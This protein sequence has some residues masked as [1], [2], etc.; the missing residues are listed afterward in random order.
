MQ[1]TIFYFMEIY[2]KN[3]FYVCEPKHA[4]RT[5]GPTYGQRALWEYLCT[6]LTL[7]LLGVNQA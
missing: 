5:G 6:D 1:T 3:V 4:L 2:E 7:I